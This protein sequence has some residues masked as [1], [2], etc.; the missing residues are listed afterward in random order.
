M[1]ISTRLSLGFAACGLLV[2]ACVGAGWWGVRS[3]EGSLASVSGP[4]WHA[5]RGSMQA[6]IA[7]GKEMVVVAAMIA[8][9]TSDAKAAAE[10]AEATNVALHEVTSAG[11]LHGEVV[12]TVSQKR[13]AHIETT[14]TL[15]DA[16][17]RWVAARDQF[18]ATTT[19]FVAFGRLVEVVGDSQ[20]E[21]IQN[22]PEQAFTWNGGLGKSWEAADGGMESNIG[23][24]TALYHLQRCVTGADIASCRAGIDEGLSFL[25]EASDSMLATGLFDVPC[26]DDPATPMSTRYRAQFAQFGSELDAFYTRT[27]ERRAADARYQQTGLAFSKAVKDLASAGEHTMNEEASTASMNASTAATRVMLLG[28]GALVMCAL[29]AVL[30][31]RAIITPLRVVSSALAEIASGDGDLTRR[32]DESRTDEL[33]VVARNFNAFVNKIGHSIAAVRAQATELTAG[34]RKL[35]ETSR[36]MASGASEQAATLQQVTAS[37]EELSSMVASTST[38]SKGASEI[39]E[40]ARTDA[41]AGTTQMKAL[42]EAMEGIKTSSAKIASIIRVIDEIAFQTN[43]L[44]LNAAVEAARAG[45]AGRGFAVVAQEVRTLA[46]RS[47]EA[48]RDTATL[49]EDSGTRAGTGVKLVSSVEDVFSRIVGGSREVAQLLTEISQATKDQSSAIHSVAGSMQ[50][51]DQATQANAAAGEELSAAATETN[52]QVASITTTLSEFRIAA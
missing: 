50:D 5:A 43:L 46:K 6:D 48:A 40:R 1:Q 28:M 36:M 32:L 7:V 14:K 12:E 42:V 39:A 31:S 8:Q 25:K 23:L 38:T 16:H 30:I 27:I 9:G 4:A 21:V 51:I 49:I 45:D 15:L 52:D 10:A 34:A 18:D 24:L 47:A 41:D 2:I 29:A 3:I 13:V 37:I 19:K 35:D 17:A 26:A 11:V 20:V 44:A 33:G 22:N